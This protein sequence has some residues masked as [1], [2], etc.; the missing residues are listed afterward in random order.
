[1]IN[2]LTFCQAPG[3]QCSQVT[4]RDF[5]QCLGSQ[6]AFTEASIS[7]AWWWGFRD[8]FFVAC[9]CFFFLWRVKAKLFFVARKE[10]IAG[11]PTIT[12]EIPLHLYLY[13]IFWRMKW[14]FLLQNGEKIVFNGK[15]HFFFR[16]FKFQLNQSELQIGWN[17]RLK[18]TRSKTCSI[19]KTV[20]P[21]NGNTINAP[22]PRCQSPGPSFAAIIGR[23]FAILCI[24]WNNVQDPYLPL[25]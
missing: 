23:T 15:S 3:T 24:F 9:F 14:V 4:H 25:E 7:L 8:A 21:C 19:C 13:I 17:E 11:W 16:P 12:G 18:Q 6:D 5:S 1:M 20:L 10:N 22:H 2:F